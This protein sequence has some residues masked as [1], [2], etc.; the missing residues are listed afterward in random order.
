MIEAGVPCGPIN[1]VDDG[2]AF[3]EELGMQPVVRAGQGDAAMP[4][5]RNPIT[6]S[7]T[8]PRYDRPP[9]TLYEH[10]DGIRHWLSQPTGAPVPQESAD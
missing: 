10:G 5:V 3:A 7:E 4:G 2:I 6:F 9:P 8:P 1:T